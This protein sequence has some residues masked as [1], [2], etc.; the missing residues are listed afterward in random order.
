[1]WTLTHGSCTVNNGSVPRLTK[2]QLHPWPSLKVEET[3]HSLAPASP[4]MATLHSLDTPH[5][6]PSAN[7]LLSLTLCSLRREPL[8]VCV[9][10]GGNK[11]R[12]SFLE[13][14]VFKK[15]SED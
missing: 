15:G 5:R 6:Y 2:P 7:L 13:E 12:E 4:I 10:I 14:G 3:H 8:T 11:I 1:M 9:W